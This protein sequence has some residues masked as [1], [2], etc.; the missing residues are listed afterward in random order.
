M[1]TIQEP[2][3]ES[4]VKKLMH[5]EGLVTLALKFLQREIN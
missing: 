4:G 3:G 5:G 1:G 2:V